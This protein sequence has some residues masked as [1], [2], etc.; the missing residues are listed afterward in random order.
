[1]SWIKENKFAAGLGGGAVVAAGLLYFVGS[2]MGSGKYAAA[3]ESFDADVAEAQGFESGP[4][5]PSQANI[6]GK[7]KALNAYKTSVEGLQAKFKAF[8]PAEIKNIAPQVFTDNLIAA[9]TELRSAFEASGAKVPEQFFVGFEKYRT[10]LAGANS[11]GVLDYQL[12][13]V[14]EV[15]MSLAKAKPSELKNVHRP[16]LAEEAP[17]GTYNA[18][19]AVARAYPLEV[20]FSGPESSLRDFMSSINSLGDR[21]VVVRTIRVVNTKKEP[22]KTT[23]AQFAKEAAAAPAAAAAAPAFGGGFVLPGDEPAA[24]P[25]AP[26]AAPAAAPK[27]GSDRILSQ[28]LGMEEV[29]V[30]VRLD[31]LQFLPEKTF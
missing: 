30:F 11:T 2:S 15:L 18:A 12:G 7:T 27:A 23:D 3:K 29:Q 26:A 10:T 4:L 19:D 24:A 22:P 25:A 14:K 1:M 5:Y 31:I 13:G 21:Y 16:E 28:V 9:N 20:T 8:R 17:G 6:D